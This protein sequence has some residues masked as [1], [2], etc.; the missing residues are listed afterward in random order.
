MIISAD[1]T[2]F[3]TLIGFTNTHSDRHSDLASCTGCVIA[4]QLALSDTED[5][6]CCDVDYLEGRALGLKEVISIFTW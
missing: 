5:L 1:F 6:N 4:F 2:R 3:I